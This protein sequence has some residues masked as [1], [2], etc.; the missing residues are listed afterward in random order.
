MVKNVLAELG[1][2][3]I[4]LSNGISMIYVITD[5]MTTFTTSSA[6]TGKS[7]EIYVAAMQSAYDTLH[8][9]IEKFQKILDKVD[10]SEQED[11]T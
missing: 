7:A 6:L 9:T 1:D 3:Q 5:G 2:I 4:E 11:M 10:L 8:N